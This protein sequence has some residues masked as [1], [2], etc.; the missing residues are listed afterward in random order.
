MKT[1]VGVCLEVF[2]RMVTLCNPVSWVKHCEK[3][4][5]E[6]FVHIL[7]KDCFYSLS[8]IVYSFLKVEFFG[9]K[10]RSQLP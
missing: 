6:I 1:P 5:S 8:L 3:P 2:F 10:I 9:N 4:T 7:Y